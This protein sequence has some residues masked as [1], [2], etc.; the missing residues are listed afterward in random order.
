[1]A[2]LEAQTGL[3]MMIVR[4]GRL[5]S[6]MD[7]NLK[8]RKSSMEERRTE[9][10]LEWLTRVYGRVRVEIMIMFPLSP[11][12]YPTHFPRTYRSSRESSSTKNDLSVS[13]N[14]F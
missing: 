1:M 13:L 10:G 6:R 9:Y 8:K 4:L 11:S 2:S 14:P 12:F 3:K 5:V 7:E